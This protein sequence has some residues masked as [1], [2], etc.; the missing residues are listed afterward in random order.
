MKIALDFDGV[1]CDTKSVWI[2]LFHETYPERKIPR[3]ID[4]N[5][6]NLTK[7]FD[8]SRQEL[9]SIFNKVRYGKHMKYASAVDGNWYI[10]VQKLINEGHEV[11][12]ISANPEGTQTAMK[13]WLSKYGMEHIPIH[14]VNLPEDKLKIDWNII[15]DDAPPLYELMKNS[16]RT[17]L[18]YTNPWNHQLNNNKNAVRVYNF[19]DAY[20]VIPHV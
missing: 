4:I 20:E 9:E 7:C 10:W 5:T 13:Y 16:D 14:L 3:D 15:I 2:K 6:Y 1:L 17:L 12:I 19:R 8:M 18:L 11:F